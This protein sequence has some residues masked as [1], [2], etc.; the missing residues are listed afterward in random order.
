MDW[1]EFIDFC[2]CL[3]PQVEQSFPFNESTL[4]FKIHQKMFALSDIY[5]QE[6]VNLK[7]DP[8]WSEELRA[9]YDGINPGFHMNKKHWNTVTFDSDVPK[10]LLKKMIQQSFDLVS[11]RKK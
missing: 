4:V 3:D 2:E 10:E 11:K 9:T 7:N 1:N 6:S 5:K 8:E